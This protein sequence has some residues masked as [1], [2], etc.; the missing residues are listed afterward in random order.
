MTHPPLTA[1][2]HFLAMFGLYQVWVNTLEYARSRGIQK[3]PP[4]SFACF[5]CHQLLKRLLFCCC[6]SVCFGKL[7]V[8]LSGACPLMFTRRRRNGNARF[9]SHFARYAITYNYHKQLLAVE[10]FV[11]NPWSSPG[12]AVGGHSPVV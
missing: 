11:L 7:D 12:T 6:L 9:P 2:L 3:I 4:N 1:C 10:A 8:R 5:N